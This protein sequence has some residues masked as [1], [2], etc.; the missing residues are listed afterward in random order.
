MV[1]KCSIL[2]AHLAQE[3]AFLNNQEEELCE[4]ME[5]EVPQV[6]NSFFKWTKSITPEQ[7]ARIKE[8]T[9]HYRL[10]LTTP[11]MLEG[12][13]AALKRPRGSSWNRSLNTV[14]C[15]S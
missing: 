9:D 2:F 3:Y 13:L 6:S 4:N 15:L 5:T 1:F 11:G 14:G 7:K 10:V 8:G 12:P